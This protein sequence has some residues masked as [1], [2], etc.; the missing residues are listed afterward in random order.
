MATTSPQ[1]TD[2]QPAPLSPDGYRTAPDQHTTAFP[3]GVPY[4]VGNE[5]CERF[6]FSVPREYTQ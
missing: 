3:P 2:A 5:V 1:L 6:S 4:I